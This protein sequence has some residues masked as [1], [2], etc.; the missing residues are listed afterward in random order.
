MAKKLAYLVNISGYTGQIFTTF[1][2]YESA[3]G[4]DDRTL[5]FS[6][7]SRDVAMQSIDFVK[8][9]ERRLILL[10]FFALLLENDLWM[11]ALTAAVIRLHMV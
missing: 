3:L 8:C 6:D 1:S 5:P 11:G 9:H 4:A 7:M 2:P 10:A